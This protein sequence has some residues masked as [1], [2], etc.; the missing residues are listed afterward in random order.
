M[1]P[2]VTTRVRGGST[3]NA[4]SQRAR[5]QSGHKPDNSPDD[6]EVS[7]CYT[8]SILSQYFFNQARAWDVNVNAYHAPCERRRQVKY[9]TNCIKNVSSFK[10]HYHI[11]NHHEKCI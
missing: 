11:R 4:A 10:F 2:A 1:F 7:L 3:G 9:L 8:R 5:N 6:T